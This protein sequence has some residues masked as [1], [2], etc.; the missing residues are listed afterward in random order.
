MALPGLEADLGITK[1]HLGIFMTLHGTIY[2]VS[3][4]LSGFAADRLSSRHLLVSSLLLCS[5]CTFIFG[6]GS[7]V[8]VL[9]GIWVLHGLIQ[10]FSFPPIAKLLAYW[11]PPKKLATKMSYFQTSHSIGAGVIIIICSWLATS[12]SWRYCFYVPGALALLGVIWIWITIRNSPSDVGLPEIDA[13]EQK[14]SQQEVNVSEKNSIGY[15]ELLMKK[16]FKS[17][18]IWILALANF[19]VYVM[20]FVFLDWG[21]TILKEWKGL[22]LI[23]SGFIIA[24]FEVA[25]IA[26]IILAGRITDKYFEG[27]THRV[28]LIYMILAMVSVFLFWKVTTAPAWLYI[29]FLISA[30]FFI[31]GVQALGGIATSKMATRR[32]AATACGFHGFWGYLSLTVSGWLVGYLTKAHGW[33]YSI[34]LITMIGLSGVILFALIWNAKADGYDDI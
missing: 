11:I 1:T 22:S 29:A 4:F 5:A 8:M 21:P 16:V 18:V 7:S 3:K 9:G 33:G 2:G 24:G 6:C 19:P 17:K 12:Y 13:L 27:K 31:Y 20:R 15:K 28:C 23:H 25:G 26:G 32:V 30:G 10:G 34:G 14:E